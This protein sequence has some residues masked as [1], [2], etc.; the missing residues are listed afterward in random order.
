MGL[1]PFKPLWYKISK[2]GWIR[3]Q[4]AKDRKGEPC[5]NRGRPRR[6][7]PDLAGMELHGKIRILTRK[8]LCLIRHGKAG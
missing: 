1:T 3:I 7:N 2:I 6:C 4:V 5:E 8:P